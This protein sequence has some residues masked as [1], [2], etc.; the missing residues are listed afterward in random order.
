MAAQARVKVWDP[1]VRLFHW[2]LVTA[3]FIAYFTEEDQ[4]RPHAIAGYVVGALIVARL[5]WGFVG[6]RHARFDDFV[7]SPRTI[8]AYSRDMLRGHAR[9]YLGHN[10]AGGAM[11]LM[12]LLA[13]A[14][15]VVTGLVIYGAD[16]GLGP[17]APWLA[18]Q[19]ALGE[20]LEEAHEFLAN[21]TLFLVLLHVGGVI[22]G[23]FMHRENLIRAMI[24]GYKRQKENDGPSATTAV[25]G[26]RRRGRRMT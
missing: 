12:L 1:F 22:V 3:F 5:A 9:R 19:E 4:L 14:A 2:S 7:R 25:T 6:P 17:L 16:K 21:F 24:N 11:I 23:S 8:F 15:T 26:E 10:P 20:S 13:L 18:G